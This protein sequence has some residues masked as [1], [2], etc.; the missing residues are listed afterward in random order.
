MPWICGDVFRIFWRSYSYPIILKVARIYPGAWNWIITVFERC[1]GAKNSRS[2]AH[3]YIPA[4]SWSSYFCNDRITVSNQIWSLRIVSVN[5][6]PPSWPRTNFKRCKNT[7]WSQRNANSSIST[8]ILQCTLQTWKFKSLLHQN[9]SS[10]RAETWWLSSS[11]ICKSIFC[12][13]YEK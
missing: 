6:Q 10:D 9:H 3:T 8:Y 11:P 4:R 12:L 1:T 5:P 7:F 13:K 2:C